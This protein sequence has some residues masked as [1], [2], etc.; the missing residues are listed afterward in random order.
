[1]S[2]LKLFEEQDESLYKIQKNCA[3]G[4]YTLYRYA[5]G[6]RKIENM[7]LDILFRLSLY[8]NIE[9]YDLYIKML[10]YQKKRGV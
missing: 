2:K 7:P 9:A 6:Q 1:M 4:Q 10:D 5:K 3:L 8:L